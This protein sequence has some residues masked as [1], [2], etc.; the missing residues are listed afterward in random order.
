MQQDRVTSTRQIAALA[1][2]FATFFLAVPVFAEANTWQDLRDEL[3]DGRFMAKSDAVLSLD[4]PYRT[5][6][7]ARTNM[8]VRM[9]APQGQTFRSVSLILDD[10]PMP[11]SAQIAF[12]DPISTFEFTATMR[13]N[14]PTPVHAVAELS[15]GQL[16]VAETFVKTSGTGACSAPPGTDPIEALATL[17]QME[18]AIRQANP[19]TATL[20]S[21]L[22]RDA[23]SVLDLEVSIKH[24]SHSGMQMNQISLLYIP[25][26]YV[27][28]LQLNLNGAPFATMTGS[29]SLSENPQVTVSVPSGTNRVKAILTD[30]DGTVTEAERSLADY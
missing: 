28:T 26:R 14:G 17:G 1:A 18:L 30:T 22:R 21:T 8:S 2:L 7:D 13:V 4:A 10:N 25:A 15:N 23:N 12:A 11:V 19:D 3:Y 27:E 9:A 20:V 29:I 5:T 24:P 16:Y 6:D